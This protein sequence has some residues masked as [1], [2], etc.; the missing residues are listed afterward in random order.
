LVS[1]LLLMV[2]SLW[3]VISLLIRCTYPRPCKASIDSAYRLLLQKSGA[4]SYHTSPFR[5][6][7]QHAPVL[8]WFTD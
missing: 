6:R 4:D 7:Q 1:A 2:C 3:V 5:T 8:P